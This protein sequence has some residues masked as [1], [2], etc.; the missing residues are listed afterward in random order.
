[1]RLATPGAFNLANLLAAVL[2]AMRLTGVSLRDLA[3]LVPDLRPVRGRMERIDAGQPFDVIVDFAHNPDSFE[4]VLSTMRGLARARLIALFG[5]AGDRDREKRPIQGEIASRY[6]E[7]LILAD[8]D[9]RSESPYAILKQI[10]AGCVGHV[11][12]Q[13]L[14]L[15]P[16]RAV[17]V[18]HAMRLARPGD[19]V[20]LLGKGHETS[21]I[22]AD[23]TV[24]WDE[25][26][27]AREA[28]RDLGYRA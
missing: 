12:G 15:I 21:I 27:A 28:L 10:A 26:T 17:A 25:A 22:Y 3:P 24:P 20:L 19:T 14:Y 18:R 5:S 4:K 13:D 8:E 9:P 7:V 2:T 23:R 11:E 16:D 1:V 6:C